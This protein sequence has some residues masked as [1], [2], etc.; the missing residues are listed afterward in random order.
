MLQFLLETMRMKMKK[1]LMVGSRQACSWCQVPIEL[2]YAGL[3]RESQE[4]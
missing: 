4:G 3:I 1:T 2:E